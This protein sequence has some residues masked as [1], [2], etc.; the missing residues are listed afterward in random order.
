M[1]VVLD[2]CVPQPFRH[3]LPSHDVV[4]ARYLGLSLVEDLELLAAIEGQ[5]DVLITCD[6]GIPWQVNF[7]GR[8]IAVLVLRAK[9]NKIADLLPLVPQLIEA[10]E[11]IKPGEV[12]EVS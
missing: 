10:L 2:A 1:K 12:R 5:F 11:S 6:R 9:S 8:N 3:T 7:R 4:T